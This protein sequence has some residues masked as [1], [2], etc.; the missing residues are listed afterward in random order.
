LSFPLGPTGPA[1]PARPVA[2][3]R[4]CRGR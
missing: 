2:R 3:T 1:V 4:C